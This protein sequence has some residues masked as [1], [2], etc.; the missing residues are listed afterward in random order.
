MQEE[1]RQLR[2]TDDRVILSRVT[3][4][5]LTLCNP[6]VV[7]T[8]FLTF[9]SDGVVVKPY[10]VCFFNNQLAY[11]FF[12]HNIHVLNVT[13]DHHHIR[14]NGMPPSPCLGQGH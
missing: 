2:L 13:K 6:S 12:H 9:A 5:Y 14:N 1:T 4:D 8:C 7:H 11:S 3:S 10:L